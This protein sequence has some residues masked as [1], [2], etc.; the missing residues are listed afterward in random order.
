M[1]YHPS[2]NTGIQV[3][4]IGFGAWWELQDDADSRLI[5]HKALDMGC[6]FGKKIK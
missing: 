3:S 5:L 4:E 1:R 6:N 2:G